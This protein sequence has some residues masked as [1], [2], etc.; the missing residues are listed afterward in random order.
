[1]STATHGTVR[2]NGQ[3][4]H[5][6]EQGTGP[7]VLLVHGFPESWHS[8]RHQLAPIADAGFRAVAVDMR[9]YGRSSKPPHIHDYRVI[10]LV[11]DCVGVVEAL[12]E[13][14]AV[15]AG[16]DWGSMVAWTA[17]WTRPGVFRAVVG[18]SVAFGGR[19]LLPI[20][21]ASSLGEVPP[22]EVHRVIAGPDKL[23]YQEYSVQPGALEAEMEADPHG[24]FRD[25]YYSFSGDPYPPEYEPLDVLTVSPEQVLE[26]TRAGGAVI[27]PGSKFRDGLIAPDPIPDWLAD[28]L[29][30]YVAEFER[31][32]LTAPLNWYRAIPLD[33]EL[34]A[35]YEGKPIEVPAMFI[36]SDLDVATLWGAES[37]SRFPETVPHLTETVILR[38][39]G[40]WMTREQPEQTNEALLR[41]LNGLDRSALDAEASA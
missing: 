26:F 17:A 25:L 30:F 11:A 4:I 13:S 19:G 15:I 33:W 37:I 24:F 27:E 9:G 35:P 41:F 8:W 23:F 18:M 10:E 22:H 14:T 6:V 16:H 36:G 12:G 7:I 5:L 20:A 29:D 2:A 1:M 3:R 39:C 21:G 31:T 40:H 28:D 34:L 38:G 32:G